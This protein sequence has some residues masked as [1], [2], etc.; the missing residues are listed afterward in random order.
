MNSDELNWQ[1]IRLFLAV[2]ESG[3]FSAAARHLKLGQPTLSRRIAELEQQLGQPLFF[4]FSQ[5][6]ELTALGQKLLPAAKQMAIWSVETMTQA[7]APNK[8]EGRVRITAPPG[9]CF[10]FLPQVGQKLKDKYPGI[11]LE[12]LSG[13]NTFNLTRGEADISLRTEK[14]TDN[15]LICMVSFYRGIN[16][17]VSEDVAE[18][19]SD[20]VT[21]QDLNWICWSEEYDYLQA[22][23][24]LKKEIPNFSP[25]FSAND[26]NV[27]IS[28]CCAGLGALML[29][30]F[31][32]KNPLIN[33]LKSLDIDLGKLAT[34][35]L[36]I[37]IHKRYQHVERVVI[38]TELLK[39]YFNDI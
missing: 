6:C 7:Q 32:A 36:H 16:V 13:T 9:I 30:N 35:E 24:F 5:G 4:R 27:Q 12:V 33:G 10:A 11:Q 8:V 38:V 17:Y 18:S 28:A 3:S 1:D 37:V 15:D 25:A 2:A 19:L 22:N 21:L 39:T 31:F 29:P 23:Q 26:Y 34:G 20:D 14:P